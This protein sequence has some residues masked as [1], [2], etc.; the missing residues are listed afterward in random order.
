M[1]N[2]LF[3]IA[4]SIVTVAFIATNIYILYSDQSEVPKIQYVQAYERMTA[5]DFKVERL[6]EAFIAPA[7]THTVYVKNEDAVDS[8]LVEKGDAV[9]T[10][11][12]LAILNTDRVDGERG[13]WEAERTGLLEQELTLEKMKKELTSL[14]SEAKTNNSSNVN[15]KDDVKEVDGKT[16]IELGLNVGFTVD[17]TQEGAYTQAISA[18][19]QQLSDITRQLEV[20]DAQLL[21][22]DMRPAL[23]SPVSGTISAITKQGNTLSVD[24]YSEERILVTY[25]E[26]GK[27]QELTEGQRVKIQGDTL[28]SVVLGEVL[29]VSQIPAEK[30]PLLTTYEQLTVGKTDEKLTYYEVQIVPDESLENSPF[31]AN[32]NAHITIDEALDA[33][34]VHKTWARPDTKGRVEVTKLDELGKPATVTASTPFQSGERIVMTDGITE[35]ELILHERA[36]RNYETPP[37]LYLSFPDYIPTK[38][39]FKKYGWRNYLKA[40]LVK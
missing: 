14:R 29:S 22:D 16:K 5:K 30:N 6:K 28:E 12:E 26:D 31:A 19:D 32:V 2:K 37:Q 18:I 27:W 4:I 13:M 10:G 11:Q 34:S 23:M 39:E 17:V 20:L 35:G 15:R 24:I 40:M 36:L 9:M 25:V 21:R 33:V 38:K 3:K 1:L 8:W 7:E